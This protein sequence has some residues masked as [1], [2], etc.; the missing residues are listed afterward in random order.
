MDR[1]NV[2]LLINALALV[3]VHDKKKG[4]LERIL[5]CADRTH[6]TI[7][8]IHKE[9]IESVFKQICYCATLA[10]GRHPVLRCHV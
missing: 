4:Q 8:F 2:K 1:D 9:P 7:H 6:Q 10:T 5:S 3:F